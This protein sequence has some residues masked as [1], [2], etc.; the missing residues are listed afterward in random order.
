LLLG[1][2]QR[3]TNGTGTIERESA[4]GMGR[5]D[6]SVDYKHKTYIIEIKVVHS[7]DSPDIVREEGL[8]Q[9]ARYRDKV[10][11]SAPAYLVIFDRRAAGQQA[12]WEER[13]KWESVGDVTVVGC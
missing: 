5:M 4:A 11:K 7:Y 13:I 12:S 6:I 8:E 3:V 9:I 2:L 1:F 10:K